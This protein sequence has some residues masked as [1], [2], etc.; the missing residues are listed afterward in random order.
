MES[1]QICL[2]GLQCVN[3]NVCDTFFKLQCIFSYIK[4]CVEF[5]PC[6]VDKFTVG[7]STAITVKVEHNC[8]CR[9]R[10]A[11]P[12]ARALTFEPQESRAALVRTGWNLRC[13]HV[14][15]SFLNTL[16]SFRLKRRH[17]QSKQWNVYVHDF[18][19]TNEEQS[20]YCCPVNVFFLTVLW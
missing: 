16:L 17:I 2:K 9:S 10:C 11:T 5:V 20:K 1:T 6:F 3:V 8:L 19:Q 7:R 15:W 13:I 4:V 12:R 18:T 14:P